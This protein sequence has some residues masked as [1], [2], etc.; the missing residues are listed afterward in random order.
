MTMENQEEILLLLERF[1]K[2]KQKDIP[3]ELEDLCVNFKL[4][5]LNESK[6]NRK[7]RL[8]N[9]NSKQTTKQK[10]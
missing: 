2:S 8:H 10:G 7:I 4:F 9:L 5:T 1:T 6:M 3:R